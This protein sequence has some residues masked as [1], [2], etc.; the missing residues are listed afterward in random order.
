M[1]S[2][3]ALT[4]TIGAQS[5]HI[6]LIWMYGLS[7]FYAHSCGFT[8]PTEETPSMLVNGVR[9]DELPIIHI[10]ARKNNTI[11]AV[12][13]HTGLYHHCLSCLVLLL[14]LF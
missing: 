14:L 12:T 9:Y 13:D 10:S 1:S 3:K 8:I 7:V 6:S 11:I 2:V 4:Q 5:Y